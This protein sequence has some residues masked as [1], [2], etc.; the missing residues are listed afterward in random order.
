[1]SHVRNSTQIGKTPKNESST[2][3][4]RLGMRLS[5][6]LVNVYTKH[7]VSGVTDSYKITR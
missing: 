6:N 4:E 7:T 3:V 5:C 2:N 1:M